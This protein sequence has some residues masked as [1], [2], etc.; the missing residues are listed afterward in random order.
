MMTS[1]YLRIV[2]PERA[3]YLEEDSIFSGYRVFL[4]HWSDITSYIQECYEVL[5]A[6]KFSKSLIIYGKQGCGKS[7]LANKLSGDYEITKK[8]ANTERITFDSDNIWHRITAGTN[9]ALK[10][11]NIKSA[12][13]DTVVLLAENKQTWISEAEKILSGNKDRACLVIADNCEKDYF[14][15]GLLNISDE[16]YLQTGRSATAIRSAAHRFVELSRTSLR[17]CFFIF[18]TN[19]EDF[20]LAFDNHVNDQHK[21]LIDIRDLK[22]PPDNQKEAIVRINVNRLNTLSYWVCIDRAGPAEKTAVWQTLKSADTFPATFNAVDNAIRSSAQNRQGRPARKCILNAYV[23]TNAED[24]SGMIAAELTSDDYEDIYTGANFAIRMYKSKWGSL[25]GDTREQK[26]LSSEWHLK[27]VVSSDRVVSVILMGDDLAKEII[28]ATTT[29]HG[30]GTHEKTK[31][32]YQ[33]NLR[34]LDEA[35]SMKIQ[36]PDNSAFWS[37]GSVRNNDYE[38]R[39]KEFFPTYNTSGSGFLNARPDL[40]NTDYMP[41]TVLNAGNEMPETINTAIRREANTVEFTAIK[42]FT[43]QKLI[44]YLSS[45]KIKNYVNAVQE[46]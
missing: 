41:C 25:F 8:S 33:A 28:T 17:G 44:S 23:I 15:K 18:F 14:L 26:M 13:C 36:V 40:I 11:D 3:E 27:V 30:P 7:V 9:E 12:I 38:G 16:V 45:N 5:R 29:Y 24:V 35:L 20:A 46:Q 21:G 32:Q 31:Q 22:M 4:D 10:S 2:Y 19:D 42:D 37:K 6:R 34:R 39:L 1:D 43:P